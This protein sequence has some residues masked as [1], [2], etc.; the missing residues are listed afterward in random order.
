MIMSEY[1]PYRTEEEIANLVEENR[2]MK[3]EKNMLHNVINEY[4]KEIEKIKKDNEDFIGQL[5]TKNKKE[6]EIHNKEIAQIKIDNENILLTKQNSAYKYD[7]IYK[8][9]DRLVKG[10]QR[11]I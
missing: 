6:I 7:G 8:G 4:K 5:T 11:Q 1:I 3:L 9:N 10:G 2:I